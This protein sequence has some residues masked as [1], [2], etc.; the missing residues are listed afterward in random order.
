MATLVQQTSTQLYDYPEYPSS[1][2][3]D[4]VVQSVTNA[5]KRLSQISTSTTNSNKKRKSQS[6]IGPWKL[7]RTL[8]RG[9]TGRV[10]LAK[11]INTGQLAAVKI[12]PK[13]NFKKLENPKY[14]RASITANKDRL[15]YGIEREIIIMK[16]INHQNIMGLYD[17]WENKNDLYL[18]LEYIEGGELFDYLIKRG[19]LS[20][21]EAIQ[22][23]KQIIDGIHYL[24]QFNICH[25]DLKPENL[26]LDFNKNIKIADFGMAA[27]EVREKL[28][29]TSCGSPH[30]ASPEIV[31]GKNYHGAPSDIWSC[32]IILFALLTGHLP[33]DDENIRKLLLKVQSGQFVMPDYLSWEAQDLISKMLCVDPNDRIT[34]DV[35]MTHPLLTKYPNLGVSNKSD[36]DPSKINVNPI[37]SADKIDTEIL[38]NLTVLFHNCEEET[39]ISKL[40]SPAKCPEKM[41]YYLLMKYRNDHNPINNSTST[42]D[43]PD[44]KS[45]TR[46][47]PRST[48]IVKTVTVDD[49]TGKSHTTITKVHLQQSSINRKVL[50]NITNAT[51]SS[52]KNFTAST[53]FNKKKIL[54]AN[55]NKTR[56][57]NSISQKSLRKRLPSPA[58]TPTRQTSTPPQ[59]SPP[60]INRG[61]H[62]YSVLM[63]D[64]ALDLPSE[65]DKENSIPKISVSQS[66]TFTAQNKNKFGGTNKSLLNFGSII[67]DAFSEEHKEAQQINPL[68]SRNVLLQNREQNLAAKVHQINEERDRKLKIHDE[69]ER[70]IKEEK[71]LR[72][73]KE[74][75]ELMKEQ[76][77]KLLILKQEQKEAAL[78]LKAN[79]KTS[80]EAST[81]AAQERRHFTEPSKSASSLDPRSASLFRAR[82]LASPSSYASLRLSNTPAVSS[83]PTNPQSVLKSLGIS[84]NSAPK[85]LTS[86][87]K[88][89]GSRNLNS[90]LN[91]NRELSEH[92]DVS[93]NEFNKIEG[94]IY[95][96]EAELDQTES[97][98][99][100]SSHSK[101]YRS[102]VDGS[103]D[104]YM[105]SG[106][107]HT[108]SR[109]LTS[110]QINTSAISEKTINKGF[111]PNPRFSKFSVSGLLNQKPNEEGDS[112]IQK[113]GLS[114]GGTIKRKSI[115]EPLAEGLKTQSIPTSAGN[116]MLKKYSANEFLGLGIDVNANESSL[117]I[118]DFSA[119]FTGVDTD[120]SLGEDE[121]DG[122]YDSDDTAIGEF[123]YTID[124]ANDDDR[125]LVEDETEQFG[126]DLS[127]F[128][129]ISARTAKVA[130]KN[131]SPP[132]I[133]SSKN[134]SLEEVNGKNQE[135]MNAIGSMYKDYEGFVKNRE[136][137]N[138]LDANIPNLKNPDHFEN[139]EEFNDSPKA[140]DTEN[141]VQ[142]RGR[143][144][145]IDRHENETQNVNN[146]KKQQPPSPKI[147]IT[148]ISKHVEIV[149]EDNGLQRRTST[150][151]SYRRSSQIIENYIEVKS[152]KES[153]FRKLSLKPKREAPKAP[154][155]GSNRFSRLSMLSKPLVDSD[156]PKQNWFQ[157]FLHS[158]GTP[159]QVSLAS[160]N[161]KD[162]K[163]INSGLTSGELIK[164]IK[165]QL[166]LKK[167]DGSISKITMD[168]NFGLING[169]IPAKF[170]GGRKLRFKM[171][172]ID[173]ISTSSLHLH[174]VRGSERGFRSFS[175]IVEYIIQQEEVAQTNK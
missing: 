100:H 78:R 86:S 173:L 71:E 160:N 81:T 114:T 170:A 171:E 35:I 162:V 101:T 4:K 9:S 6:K 28:L 145:T 129:V 125:S 117:G 102:L 127:T 103:K 57:I 166:H 115:Y 31:A 46:S 59:Q 5:T 38:K 83:Q 154:E 105:N 134:N 157:K 89:S 136:S 76:N 91:L 1:V 96:E 18:I 144:S 122:N 140:D 15:P 108:L 150:Y 167:M 139:E 27:L 155:K 60:K 84:V 174:R 121:N 135:N 61:Q 90:Y 131:S 32:G 7:G 113:N 130:M 94:Q 65:E 156:K 47:I 138:L 8:G 40:L 21:H 68:Q 36:F 44:N 164:V 72:E 48:S 92:K 151:E 17:V 120:I 128:D 33:F 29:E 98:K 62:A 97:V 14:K 123:D 85:K 112:I 111:I 26:L 64:G 34:I 88:S 19:K 25:R 132:N 99:R 52:S 12:V 146:N 172:I 175:D 118:R 51:N 50:G 77:R 142:S 67:D 45:P 147:E 73:R 63:D 149:D 82:S 169:E 37:E 2:N 133:V 109:K 20:E 153:V 55:Q 66:K 158:F 79:L 87:L 124:H 43:E 168:E 165:K 75:E 143:A 39:M 152:P 107:N 56:P 116:G 11:N 137:T 13:A 126:R 3:V 69:K 41:F 80:N 58:T 141:R 23:F 159:K 24:H 93:L 16:L 104:T 119:D 49:T 42:F 53:S 106:S 70:K 54:L 22:Y 148:E 163:V 10:R 74:K 161:V 95:E 110:D 30:Y